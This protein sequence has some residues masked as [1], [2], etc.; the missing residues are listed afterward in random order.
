MICYDPFHVVKVVTDALD[1]LRRRHWQAARTLPDQDLATMYKGA[2]WA[3]L[4]NQPDLTY[5]QAVTLATLRGCLLYTS[6]SP[7]D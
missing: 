5:T 2:R 1:E 7:R 6:P 3:L 4:K